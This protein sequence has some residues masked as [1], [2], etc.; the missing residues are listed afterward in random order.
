MI[1]GSDSVIE[2]WIKLMQLAE[3]TAIKPDSGGEALAPMLHANGRLILSIRKDID[4]SG[5]NLK[6]VDIAGL[7]LKFD[8]AENQKLIEE[9]KKL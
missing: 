3:S 8:D 4:Y 5:T 1:W 2:C 9:L 6:E 7:I